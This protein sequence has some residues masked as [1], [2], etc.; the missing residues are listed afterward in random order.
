M[1]GEMGGNEEVLMRSIPFQCF[2]GESVGG[3]TIAAANIQG[4]PRAYPRLPVDFLTRAQDN[5]NRENVRYGQ[6]IILIISYL[7][8]AHDL[9]LIRV[10]RGY[11][12][13]LR[14]PTDI[15]QLASRR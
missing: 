1:M 9:G 14:I 8:L 15:R 13:P 2:C 11:T 10:G 7:N 5:P 4:L 12:L 6:K 3:C